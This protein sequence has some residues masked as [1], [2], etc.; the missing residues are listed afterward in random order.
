V[1]GEDLGAPAGERA[2]ERADLR[3]LVGPTALDGLVEQERGVDRLLGEVDIAHRL[4]GDPGAEHLLV[5]VAHLEAEQHPLEAGALQAL[6]A[7]QHQLSDPVEGI[8]PA[9]PMAEG[10]VLDPAAHLIEAA[11]GDPHDVERVGHPDRVIEPAIQARAVGL[12]QVGRHHAHAGEPRRRLAIEPGSQ[13]RGAV[14]RDHVDHDL[15]PQ[16]DQAGRKERRVIL[17]GGQPR[18]LVDAEGA[19]LADPLRVVDQG[20][21]V[22]AH[23]VHHG[24]P[25]DPELVCHLDDRPRVAAHLAAALGAGTVGQQAARRER[26]RGL[27]PGPR[28]ARGLLAAP[29]ALHPHQAGGPPEGGQVAVLDRHPILRDGDHAAP[30]AADQLGDRFDADHHLRLVLGDLQHA[31]SGQAEHRLGNAGSVGHPSGASS[32]WRPS[33][34]ATTT[35]APG[36]RSAATRYP[37]FPTWIGRA[38]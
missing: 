12:G 32:S 2:P 1:V 9:S 25:R 11:V 19:H 21:A 31:E 28:R 3:N 14:S 22:L 34:A 37:P 27:G 10:L 24:V 5:G 26:L 6:G 8:A 23:R 7:G 38:R 18:G 30:G 35:G 36:T 4:L 17:G 13:R 33:S 15:G 16:V 29:A 20:F